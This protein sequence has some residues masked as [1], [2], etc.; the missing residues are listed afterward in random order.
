MGSSRHRGTP[1]AAKRLGE[2]SSR[3][4]EVLDLLSQGLTNRELAGRLRLSIH[5][6]KY[7]VSGIY[8]KLGVGNRTEA[9][10][11]Y[12]S[13]QPPNGGA[14]CCGHGRPEP[15]GGSAPTGGDGL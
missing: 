12:L 14:P 4:R 8:R 3:E 1:A 15:G 6:V 2:L 13:A 10:A 11:A 9:A 5:A 7:H